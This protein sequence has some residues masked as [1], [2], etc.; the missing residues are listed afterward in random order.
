MPAFEGNTLYPEVFF[1]LNLRDHLRHLVQLAYPLIHL[2]GCKRITFGKLLLFGQGL[3]KYLYL[4]RKDLYHAGIFLRIRLQ[5]Y[6][7]G[8]TKRYPVLHVHDFI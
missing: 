4:V 5:E 7:D 2:S 8:Y 1:F 3:M 6:Y